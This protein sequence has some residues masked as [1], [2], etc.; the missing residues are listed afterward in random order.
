MLDKAVILARGLGTRMQ[1]ADA[2]AE[3]TPEQA[4]A[5]DA[6]VK[7]M[8]PIGR[9]FLDYVLTALADAGYR[10]ACLVVAPEHD[11]V[12]EYYAGVS[13]RR[14]A[15]EFAVQV[16]PNGTS[17]AVAAAEDFAAGEPFL[18]INSD[19]YYP[20]AALR[21]MRRDVTGSALAAFT[22]SGLLR[23]NI[24]PERIATYAIVQ[25]DEAGR[26]V[27]I[28]EK[29]TDADMAAAGEPVR[30]SMNCWRFEPSI[31]DGCRAI[32][33]SAR[34]EWELPDAVRYAMEH[35]GVTFQTV[36]INEPVLDLSHRSDIAA[37]KREL[38]NVEVDL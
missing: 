16:E 13:S 7:A 4:A 2:S 10:R 34:G 31:F 30:V 32:G 24:P 3:L 36:T 1:Q 35:L 29:P 22:R 18:A 27:R 19:N 21:A 14:I 11:E 28:V 17:D 6:G 23:G 8:I 15:V 25:A 26:L 5:A 20:V 37:V 9:P 38:A 33:P 12:R